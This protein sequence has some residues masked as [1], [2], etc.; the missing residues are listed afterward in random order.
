M[1]NYIGLPLQKVELMANAKDY[2]II[3]TDSVHLIGKPG[4]YVLNQTPK[5][6]SMV[7]RGRTIY[8]VVSRYKADE[9]ISDNLPT[10]YG[11]K[12]DFKSR[13]LE[14]LYQ[15]KL[16]IVGNKYDPGPSGHI[17]EARRNGELIADADGKKLGVVM[18]KGDTIEIIISSNQGGE[19]NIPNL[20]CKTLA[21]ARFEIEASGIKLGIV[22]QEGVVENLDDGYII[23]QSPEFDKSKKIKM[24]SSISVTVSQTYPDDCQP[25]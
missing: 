18:Y 22:S 3:I 12:Y 19:I 11:E 2:E 15:L 16:K 25:R 4:G 5:H 1:A 14:S 23:S 20:K 24:Q 21:E 17:L 7:K 9:L 8:L 10:I 6:N 13:E